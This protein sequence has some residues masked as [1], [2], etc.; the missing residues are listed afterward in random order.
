MKY[1][2]DGFY[3]LEVVNFVRRALNGEEALEFPDLL[4]CAYA[5]VCSDPRDRVFAML[6]MVGKGFQD[7]IQIAYSK[8]CGEDAIQ[9]YIHCA[10]AC[11]EE[12]LPSILELVGRRQRI[13]ALP[14]WCPNL[15]VDT[16]KPYGQMFRPWHRAGILDD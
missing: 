13:P 14:S 6:G 12:S 3:G 16:E 8:E 5:K 11:I 10:K 2:E 4:D 15:D 1:H 7:R 9:T